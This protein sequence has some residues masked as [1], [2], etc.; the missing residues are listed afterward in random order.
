MILISIPKHVIRS[1]LAVP[2]LLWLCFLMSA[3][4]AC[5]VIPKPPAETSRG[6]WGSVV[7]AQARFTPA[8]NFETFAVGKTKGAAKG[9]IMGAGLGVAGTAAFAVAG[10]P[11]AAVIAPYL[12]VTM[13]PALATGMGA[14]GGF[15]S[16]TVEDA[17]AVD[18]M[19][20]QNLKALNIQT[21]LA[22][23]VAKSVRNDT[24]QV[25]SINENVGPAAL[26][27][28]GDY[29]ELAQIGFGGVL[30]IA[31]TDVGFEGAVK[32]LRFFMVVR[33]LMIRPGDGEHLYERK[34][35][36]ESDPYDGTCWAAKN[37]ALFE[38]E[39]HRA[40]ASIAESIVEQVFLLTAL[41]LETNYRDPDQKIHHI[42]SIGGGQACGLAWRLPP[43]EYFPTIFSDR[44]RTNWNRFPV[45][46]TRMPTLEWE[47]FPRVIDQHTRY[48]PLLNTVSNIRYDLRIW[49]VVSDTPP[50]LVYERRALTVPTHTLDQ[51]L[52]SGT[53][54]FWSIR[55]RF[56]VNGKTRATRWGCYRAPM[57]DV[58]G[59]HIKPP[60]SPATM[61]GVIATPGGAYRDPCTMDF[62]PTALYYRFK[63][64]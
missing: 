1:H 53:R 47:P 38:A 43:R 58:M 26:K 55:A 49:K 23:L 12:A 52:K 44:N 14:A 35:V 34:F 21:T 62:I 9:A 51:P 41:P 25:L 20:Q 39:L 54:Y 46:A 37:A 11:L 59:T 63:T 8:T 19:I 56:D 5:A 10:G 22:E 15:S 48:A 16:V 2:R 30:E 29:G 61:V 17:K 18:A 50:Q 13:V 24:G 42:L 27:A 6:E 60:A 31:A 28:K 3:V 45:V 57:V 40:Y 7:I 36:Y 64:P 32:T 33:V 4:T